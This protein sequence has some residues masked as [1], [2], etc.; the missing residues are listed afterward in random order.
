M[1][2]LPVVSKEGA[3]INQVLKM[4]SVVKKEKMERNVIYLIEEKETEEAP[5]A[6]LAVHMGVS[7]ETLLISTL[8]TELMKL[9]V[10][11]DDVEERKK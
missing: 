2:N 3:V 11:L 4:P 1:V 7:D 6:S 10:V 5:V 8:E 9:E